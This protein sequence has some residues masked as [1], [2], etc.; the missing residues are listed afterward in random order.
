LPDN[1]ENRRRKDF[2]LQ[3]HTKIRDFQV[4]VSEGD[5]WKI[6]SSLGTAER[7]AYSRVEHPTASAFLMQ[8]E[9]Y[10]KNYLIV[11]FS[12]KGNAAYIFDLADFEDRDVTL[13]TPRFELKNHLKFDKT[14]RIIHNGD[15]EWNARSMLAAQFGITP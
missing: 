5:H 4:A 11:E 1:S 6:R 10:G 13:R 3:Y 2:W 15:W 12:E 14:H 8:F 9:G 7:I